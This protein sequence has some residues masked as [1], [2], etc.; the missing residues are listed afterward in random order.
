MNNEKIDK[1]DVHVTHNLSTRENNPD[2][3]KPSDP[4]EFFLRN[5]YNM[6]KIG[7]RY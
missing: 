5:F 4:R 2:R 7:V 6:A 3:K 1:M